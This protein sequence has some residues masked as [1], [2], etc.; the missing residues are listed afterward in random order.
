VEPRVVGSNPIAH[1]NIFLSRTDLQ[2]SSPALLFLF[3]N[4]EQLGTDR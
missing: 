2:F 1:P 3:P 4:W